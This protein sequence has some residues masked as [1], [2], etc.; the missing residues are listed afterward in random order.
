MK[1]THYFLIIVILMGFSLAACS[2]AAE[3]SP[4]A[5]SAPTS[6]IAELS[7]AEATPEPTTATQPTATTGQSEEPAQVEVKAQA[8]SNLNLRAG[9]GTNYAIVG[10]L[11]ANA[12]AVALGRN[13]NGSWLQVR[14]EAGATAWLT[15]DPALVKV[16]QAVAAN[17]PVVEAPPPA[18]NASHPLVN[19]VLN[20]IPLVV[21]HGG[22]FT[23]ASHGGL[24]Y[25]L[26][27][28]REGNVIGPYAGDFV[29]DGN[30]V[31]FKLSGGALVLIRENP[32]AR[33][34]GGAEFLPFDQAMKLFES[35][36]ISWTGD[37]GQTGRGV[38]GCD[39]KAP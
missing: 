34:E 12:E 31:L 19:R 5:P 2:P 4:P 14:T 16:D 9:P 13:E 17:L 36:Q 23:C 25:L 20:E 29:Y 37:F 27:E 1:L 33:F 10:Q 6:T 28:V 32:I 18:Y 30:N 15:G 26:P 3:E 24:N 21:H 35:D 8:L 22:R 7:S 39:P 11:P 38:P